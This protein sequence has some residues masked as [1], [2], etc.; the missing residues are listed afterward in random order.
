MGLMTPTTMGTATRRQAAR[1]GV[2]RMV[3]RR[4]SFSRT[5]TT[6]RSRM[7]SQSWRRRPLRKMLKTMRTSMTA[8][9]D[10]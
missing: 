7:G 5:A 10:T 4:A 3:N 6:R 2:A 8:A 9:P 1:A